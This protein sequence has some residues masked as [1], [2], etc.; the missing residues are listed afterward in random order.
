LSNF[1][2]TLQSV[3]G[4]VVA[5]TEVAPGIYEVEYRLPGKNYVNKASGVEELPK[6]TVYDPNIYSDAQMSSMASEAAARAQIQF[7]A[8][9][10]PE[11]YVKVGDV[12]F[13]APINIDK[14]TGA[15]NGI[16]TVFPRVPKGGR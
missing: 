8:T 6:K 12:W 14:V 16:R 9:G 3:N 10:N 13:F 1:E 11:Q 2:T 15:V 5:K 7:Q 4:Q